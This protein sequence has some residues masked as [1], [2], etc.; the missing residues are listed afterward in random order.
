MLIQHNLSSVVLKLCCTLRQVVVRI[1]KRVAGNNRK[2]SDRGCRNKLKGE[3]RGGHWTER[4]K[5]EERESDREREVL[6]MCPGIRRDDSPTNF[7]NHFSRSLAFN[8]DY[9]SHSWSIERHILGL[10]T[11]GSNP[12]PPPI[13]THVVA[14]QTTRNVL[15]ATECMHQW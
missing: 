5:G 10:K 8:E 1:S 7:G 9:S 2:G 11:I 12:P 15:C 6:V 4:G 14:I 13:S 3:G